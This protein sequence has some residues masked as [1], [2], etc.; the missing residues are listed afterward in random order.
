MVERG[1][2]DTIV[3]VLGQRIGIEADA[4][5]PAIY[6]PGDTGRQRKEYFVTDDKIAVIDVVG[7]LVK[8]TSGAFL[9]GGP[10]TY[11]EV[12]TEFMD[13]ITDPEIAGVL[14]QVDSPGGESTGAFELSDLIHSQRGSKPIFAAADGDA[15]S[16]A[17]AVAS[18]ADRLFVTKSGGVGSIGVWMMHVDQSGLNA[19]VGLKPTYLF[20]GARKID[21]NPHEPLGK[22]ARA[23]FQ[24]EVD[25]IYGMFVDTVARN[26]SMDAANVQ[27][28]EARLFFGT[29]AIESG[30]ADEVG[31]LADAL[32][33]LR[34]TIA[35][36][37]KST[38]AARSAAATSNKGAF[39]MDETTK[40][41]VADEQ[42][43]PEPEKEPES[44]DAQSG[45]PALNVVALAYAVDVVEL[46]GLAGL[47]QMAA[48]FL[49]KSATIEDVRTGLQTARAALDS[50][51]Q[52]H[53]HVLPESGA[54]SS[55]PGAKTSTEQSAIVRAAE[56]LAGAG[57][58]QK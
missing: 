1:K 45:A 31:T 13:A 43:A 30:L 6:G 23:S 3:A 14:L 12:E 20:A 49:K 25:R 28:T 55:K 29:D 48:D 56:K 11:S 32:A 27:G 40:E 35:S 2:L 8:R 53:S 7:P 33:A 17:Y 37:S 18:A 22:E 51:T 9:S 47:P 38:S 26:R 58:E 54:D 10:T 15:F 16:A 34:S 57:K 24:S 42:T 19:K 50:E 44:T 46:C 5:E 36:K 41:P 39:H 21:G 52:V 4:V